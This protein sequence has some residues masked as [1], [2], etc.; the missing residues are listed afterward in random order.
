MSHFALIPL[1]SIALNRKI[2]N[3][4]L[5]SED[6]KVQSAKVLLTD[7]LPK[8][9]LNIFR[10]SVCGHHIPFAFNNFAVG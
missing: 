1:Y 7:E 6:L 3:L 5:S 8:Y 9:Y 4:I 2:C 10:I